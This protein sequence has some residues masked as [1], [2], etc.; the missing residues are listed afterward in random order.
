MS[1]KRDLCREDVE[2]YLDTHHDIAMEIFAAKATPELVDGWL[3]KHS[4]GH[5]A[6]SMSSHE[7]GSWPDVS[8]CASNTDKHKM[9]HSLR[10]SFAGASGSLRSLLSPRKRKVVRRNKSA[11]KQLDEKDLFMELIRDIAD[12]L[13]LHTLSHKILMNVSILTNGDRCSLFLARGNRDNRYLVSKLFDVTENSTVEDALHSEEDEIRIPFGQGIAG[14]VAQTKETVNIK[15]AYED[16]RF[17][18]EV[19]KRTGYRTYSILCMP[20]INHDGDVI[21]VAQVINKVSGSHEFTN[22]DEEVFRNYLTFCG[23]GIMNAQLFE[24]SV[25]EYK[26]NQMLLQLARGIFEEQTSLE[27]VVHKIMKEAITL[28][29]CERCL[30]FLLE[31]HDKSEFHAGFSKAF[32]LLAKNKEEVRQP[33]DDSLNKSVYSEIAKYVALT[34][35]TINIEKFDMQSKFKLVAEVDMDF[36]LHTL[37]CQPIYNSQN[38][39]VGV[40]EMINKIGTALNPTFTDQDENLFEAFAIFC[41]LGIHNTQMY[42]SAVKL[43]AKQQVALE[44]LSYHATAQ[45]DEVEKLK[46]AGP[47][48]SSD[49]LNLHNFTFN[50]F[51]LEEDETLQ[52][53]IC[54]FEECNLINKFHIPYDVLCRWLLSVRKN[55]RPVIYHNWRHAFNVAQ[56]MFAMFKSGGMGQVMSDLESFAL[57]VACLCHDLDHRGTNNAF[58]LKTAS[59]LSQLY[60]TSTMEHHHFDHCIMILNSEGNN[61][62]QFLSPEDYRELIRML[63]SAILSTD[64]ALYFKKRN[65]FF[66]LVEQGVKDWHNPRHRDLLRGMMMTACD[67][68]AITKPWEV[69]RRVAELVASEFFEQGDM[70]REQLKEEPIAMMD[71]KKKS[72]LPKM[73]VGFIDAICM[74][75]YKNLASMQPQL[76]PLYQGMQQNRSQWQQLADTEAQKTIEA[77]KAE[78]EKKKRKTIREQAKE[79]NAT[80]KDEK[81][82]LAKQAQ[83]E[84]ASSKGVEAATQSK[85]QRNSR[86]STTSGE[87]GRVSNVV[88][89]QCKEALAPSKNRSSFC[90]LL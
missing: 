41:G 51:S 20:I 40:A 81:A 8:A 53:S 64:L 82:Y 56:T 27:S 25:N 26:R 28:L 48:E 21:G 50:D 80:A 46:Q 54:M 75:V 85:N 77:Q 18:P 66:K 6:K 43:M 5:V 29:K 76:A 65:D 78:E 37:L 3:S 87:H 57:L 13:D 16:P 11:L 69:Q 10:K 17:N 12:E 60:S 89:S 67:V 14:H 34:G 61:I 88:S 70:E 33:S 68:S 1:E 35:K 38:K 9:L 84:A 73:Q 90:L 55:Y 2:K 42:E 24:M 31:D 74:P 59:A 4:V 52:A 72:E 30:V 49:K 79:R 86:G 19:D 22:K 23:I 63:E 32:D 44:V 58:Q 83:E 62:F 47:V 71:R 15:N 45:Q 39:I 36:K 7:I